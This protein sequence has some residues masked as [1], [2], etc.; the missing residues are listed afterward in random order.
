MVSLM[1][2]DSMTI[3]SE[4]VYSVYNENQILDG[5]IIV[6]TTYEKNGYRITH[7]SMGDQTISSPER[8]P[9]PVLIIA[10]HGNVHVTMIE[11]K[12]KREKDLRQCQCY[13]RPAN[14]LC[15]YSA[16][17]GKAI[18]T[19]IRI[20]HD[21]EIAMRIKEGNIFDFMNMVFYEPGHISC[22]HLIQDEQFCIKLKAYSESEK[23]TDIS[24]T[25]FVATTLE[26]YVRINM[27]DREY[28]L[29]PG[30]SYFIEKGVEYSVSVVAKTKVVLLYLGD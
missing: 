13:L 4:K 9:Y 3:Y 25:S 20:H 5:A 18:L 1:Q 8:F 28:C 27:K 2:G 17:D 6:H 24:D 15:F 30:K 29:T 14:S 21:S 16:E 7:Y 10:S 26:G 22:T 19:E 12:E 23:I 11:G